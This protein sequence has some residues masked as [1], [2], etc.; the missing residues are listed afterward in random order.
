MK[1]PGPKITVIL[2]SPVY[3]TDSQGSAIPTWS[4]IGTFEGVF[5]PTNANE[6]LAYSRLAVTT[7]YK[8]YIDYDDLS[9]FIDKVNGK[10]KFTIANVDY[11]IVGV[12][13]LHEK[14]VTV[15]LQMVT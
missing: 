13:S 15:L 12:K 11:G 9:N 4:T 6:R 8:L 1:V 3:T 5:Q 14:L 2:K 10:S 7:D